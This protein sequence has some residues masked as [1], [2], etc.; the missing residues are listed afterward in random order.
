MPRSARR[1]GLL[2]GLWLSSWGRHGTIHP[3]PADL[4]ARASLCSSGFNFQ[5]ADKLARLAQGFRN[6]AG[7]TGWPRLLQRWQNWSVQPGHCKDTAAQS[8][9]EEKQTRESS[10]QVRNRLLHLGQRKIYLA[11]RHWIPPVLALRDS[12]FLIVNPKDHSSVIQTSPSLFSPRHAWMCVTNRLIRCDR[13]SSQPSHPGAHLQVNCGMRK[14]L[15][16]SLRVVESPKAR[17]P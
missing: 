9:N 4:R 7:S 1:W 12:S 2:H 14:V 8:P 11:A 3:F 5:L 15:Y 13:V 16:L 17:F 6:A 10:L